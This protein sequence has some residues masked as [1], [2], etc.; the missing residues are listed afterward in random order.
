M[1]YSLV[2]VSTADKSLSNE[3]LSKLTENA[4]SR[5]CS[6]DVSGMMLYSDGNFIQC[7]EG[8]KESIDLLMVSIRSDHRHFG[9]T[10]LWED[11]IS[12]REFADWAMGVRSPDAGFRTMARSQAFDVW[13]NTRVEEKKSVPRILL[14]DFWQ[15]V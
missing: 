14:E 8:P 12:N 6:L 10:A 5:N 11:E 7:F 13:L 1:L 4:Y 3:S 15:R 9:L 2:Y